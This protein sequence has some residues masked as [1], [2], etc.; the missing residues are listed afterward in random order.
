MVVNV[1]N[2]VPLENPSWFSN[3][4]S[5]EIT[6]ECEA[7]LEDDLEWRVIYVGSAENSSYDQVLVEVLVGPVPKGTNKFVLHSDA[8]DPAL[9]PE[10]VGIT[11]VLLV[12]SYRRQEFVRIGYYVRNEAVEEEVGPTHIARTILADKPR[13]TRLAGARFT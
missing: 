2:V 8:P 6:F 13:V 7:A 9:I 5:F 3:P 1:T 11:V 4:L 12:C 10:I